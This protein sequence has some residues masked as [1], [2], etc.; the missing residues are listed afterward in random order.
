MGTLAVIGICVLLALVGVASVKV[1]GPNNEVEQVTEEIIEEEGE[2]LLF[3]L[4][5]QRV[6]ST[7][8]NK[9]ND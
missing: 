1:L 4:H 8:P 5:D 3:N 6:D 9:D 2:T 7:Q